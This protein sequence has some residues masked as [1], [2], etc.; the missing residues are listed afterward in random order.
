[1]KF[2]FED[3]AASVEEKKMRKAPAV[4]IIADCIVLRE[5]RL[6]STLSKSSPDLF[7]YLSLF[8][9]FFSTLLKYSKHFQ[10][11]SSMEDDRFGSVSTFLCV[12]IL[13][14]VTMISFVITLFHSFYLSFFLFCF[15]G[16]SVVVIQS[17]AS[18]IV[19]R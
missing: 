12:F 19:A 1:M 17:V 9:F 7:M 14:L 8:F 10:P 16:L 11:S 15:S 18:R 13:S 4:L 6:A 5:R 2:K 3:A